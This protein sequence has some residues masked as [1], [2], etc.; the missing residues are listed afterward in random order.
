MSRY[1]GDFTRGSLV[2]LSFNS[3]DLTQTLVTISG[4]AVSVYKS[5]SAVEVAT[6]VTLTIDYDGRTGYHHILID[7]SSDGTFYAAGSDYRVVLTAGTIV[8]VPSQINTEIGQFSIENRSTQAIQALI[9]PGNG[10][11]TVTITVQDVS[12]VPIQGATVT[13]WSGTT[14]AGT[15]TTNASGVAVLTLG[16]ATYTLNV[17][18]NPLYNGSSNSLVVS[19]ATSHTYQLTALTITESDPPG[20][21]GYATTFDTSG[22]VIQ[23]DVPFSWAMTA[24]PSGTT[25]SI[26][27]STAETKTSNASGLLEILDHLAGATYQLTNLNTGSVLTYV[28]DDVTFPIAGGIL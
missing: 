8:G 13:A 26:I 23:A 3:R 19:G 16:N 18:L 25:G 10:A 28:A 22:T 15:A 21:T 6:G 11:N 2:R 5:G 24:M 27:D 17:G 12:S 4:A 7:T 9:G 1:I 20:V 14:I